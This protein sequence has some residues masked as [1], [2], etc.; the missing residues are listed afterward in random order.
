MQNAQRQFTD[1]TRELAR[2][3][4]RVGQLQQIAQR[5]KA[6]LNDH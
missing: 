1:A 4:A 6:F 3:D 5:G 2:F